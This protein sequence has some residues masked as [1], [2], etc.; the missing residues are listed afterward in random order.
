MKQLENEHVVFWIEDKILYSKF[1]HEIILNPAVC[2]EFIRLRHEIS[3]G[4]KQYWCYDFKHVIS[5]PREGKEYA[6]Q[7]GQDYLHASAAVVYNHLQKFIVNIF[8]SI[9]NPKIPFKAF[10]NKE[11]AVQWLKEIKERNEK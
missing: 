7:Y 5:M 9:K 3:A 1:K 4:E 2:S 10:T 8:I 11:K 6:E